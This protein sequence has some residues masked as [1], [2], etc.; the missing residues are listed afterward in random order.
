MHTYQ[1]NEKA[2]EMILQVKII[3]QIES[4][5]PVCI[6]VWFVNNLTGTKMWNTRFIANILLHAF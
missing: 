3:P 1:N 4:R 2:S 6:Y 5:F